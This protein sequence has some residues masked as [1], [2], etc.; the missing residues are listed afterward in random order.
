MM[1]DFPRDLRPIEGVP[2]VILCWRYQDDSISAQEYCAKFSLDFAF[3][4]LFSIIHY[5]IDMNVK[6][7]ECSNKLFSVL[8]FHYD[9]LVTCS[10]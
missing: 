8:Q 6:S 10:V 7:F 9:F 2:F 3:N 4:F 1:C 5:N